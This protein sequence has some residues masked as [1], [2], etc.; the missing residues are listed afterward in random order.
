MI[1]NLSANRVRALGTA[2]TI[3]LSFVLAGNA[4]AQEV[5]DAQAD[6]TEVAAPEAAP[7]DGD[8]IVVTGYRAA[9]ES[10]Q[11]I[12]RNADTFV[13]VISA[14][15]IGALPDRSVAEALQR[16]PGVNI[17][18][19]EKTTDPDRFSV[20]GTGVIIR[21]LPFVRSELN[22]RDIFSATGGRVLSFN[23]VSPELLGRVEVFKNV[24]ADMIDGGIA[25]TVNLVTRRPLDN[26]GLNIAGTIEATVGDLA[27]KWSPGFS[28]L[29]S[30]TWETGAGSFGLQ[31]GYAQS[32]LISRTDASQITDPC[33]R[34]GLTGDD[35]CIRA[36][37]VIDG[38]FDGDPQFDASNFPPSGSLVVPKGAGVRTTE[39]ERDRQAYSGVAQWESNDGRF[40][41]TVEYLRAE[42]QFFTDENAILAQVNNDG[43]TP[44]QAPGSTW[45]FDENGI[46]QTGV[47]TL[48]NFGGYAS[49]FGGIRTETVRFQ[50]AT[51]ANTEDVSL[52]LDFEA[53][54][55]LRFNF[56]AQH[57][58]SN[59]SRDSI[60]GAM[61]TWADIALDTSRGTPQVQFL[62]P[63]GAPDDYFTSGDYSYYWFVLDSAEQNDG[64][65]DSLRFDAEYDLSDDGFFKAA[66]FGAR[67]SDRTRTT[68]NTDFSTWGNLSAPWAGRA[69]CAPWGQTSTGADCTFEPGRLYTGLD[70]QEFATGGGAFTD[71][72]PN[73]S[74]TRNPFADGFQRGTSPAPIA[75]NSAWFFGG[76]DLLGEY[77]AG[78][79]LAQAQ[80]INAFSVTPNPFFGVQGRQFTNAVSGETVACDPFCPSEIS[81]VTEVTNA[82]Y[83]RI[84]FGHDF[85]SGMTLE[86]NFGMRYVRTKVKT[87]GLIG[88]PN[89]FFFDSGPG[90]DGDGVVQVSEIQQACTLPAP[91]GAA[92][93]YCE[94]SPER[95]AEFAAAHTGEIL[96]DDRNITFEHWLPSFNAKLDVGGGLLFRAA[97]SKNIARPD[98]QLFRAG[99]GLG[100]NTNDL[101]A[102]GTLETGP[103]FQLSTG[104]R[105]L[106]PVE[107]WNYDISAEWYFDALGSLTFSAFLKDISGFVNTGA[108]LVNYTSDS[109][110]SLDVEVNGPANDQG[111]KLTGF[112]MTYQQTYDFLPGLLSGL[113][114]QFTYTYVDGGNFS[115]ANLDSDTG[116]TLGGGTF[117]S[118]QPLAGI[119]EHT[120]NATIFYEKGPLSARAAYN[121]RSD[122]LI[123]PRD[124][125]WP[126]SPIWQESTGQ[127]DASIFYE[128]SEGIKVG[129]QGVNLLDAVTRTSQVIDFDGT[130]VTRSAF[131]NDRRFTFLARFAL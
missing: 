4:A 57:I 73:Y 48:S 113:G 54:D 53:T 88:F 83:G 42:T 14:E 122:F 78:D 65:L 62:K 68:R 95:L 39:L 7:D 92:R 117:V 76:D 115:P 91:G 108:T 127:L 16:V 44:E 110:V 109:G 106:R 20:E 86:G 63:T 3:A 35:G 74:Q 33:Y 30:N 27:D 43:E 126:Y 15:D 72:F 58:S 23:D 102:G 70:G 120:F 12:K 98:L 9:L 94:L 84:D 82:A 99:G 37:T 38:G 50:R 71:D 2:S 128:V 100:D 75:D 93:G 118:L 47:L 45:T 49:P 25:G 130:R 103:L 11:G 51:K 64:Q 10:A 34:S 96:V 111:G 87:G 22:G 8:L 56:E 19:F 85:D 29:A 46:F 121:W 114:S 26:A 125:I 69:G 31:F 107:S 5:G 55:R 21:G 67:W 41:A 97:V 81:D 104:N 101:L 80:E 89:P 116:G 129:V 36:L 79:T 131:R 32:E 119:S 61:N 52:D 59:L 17:G 60:I 112:E 40:L 66:R 1:H 28:V 90:G 24:T 13:D 6:A 123:T 105:N 77:L 124:D 18:R